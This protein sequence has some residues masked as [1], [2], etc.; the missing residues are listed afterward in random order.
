MLNSGFQ[1]TATADQ[2]F[3]HIKT[4]PNAAKG[5]KQVENNAQA[6]KAEEA[7]QI[8]MV[9]V[10]SVSIRPEEV[11]APKTLNLF[12]YKLDL[13]AKIEGF[14]ENYSQNY[15]L[16]NSHNLMVARFAEFKTAAL[17]ALMGMLGVPSDEIENL[18]KK[19]TRDAV[20][21]NKLLFEENE[22]N[23]ELLGI[24]GGP[25]KRLRTQ[26][27]VIAEIRSQLM[28]QAKNLGVDNEYTRERIL[29]IKLAQCNKILE[30]FGEEKNNLEYQY[31][32]VFFGV[33]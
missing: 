25:K 33:N 21:Q 17:G 30:K 4:Q 10:T 2:L 31:K 32:F 18:Q 15:A 20:Q 27:K 28:I 22:Y 5:S 3:Y 13:S 11:A 9:D 1:N 24:I 23:E 19:A 8:K 26:G 6:K 16:T 29:E 7:P 14:K 12:G